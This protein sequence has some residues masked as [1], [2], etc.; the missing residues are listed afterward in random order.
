[1]QQMIAETLNACLTGVERR[2]HELYNN[3][4]TSLLYRLILGDE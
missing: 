4:K 3:D 2:N 1:M